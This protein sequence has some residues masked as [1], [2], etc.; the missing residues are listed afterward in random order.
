MARERPT[1]DTV[2]T[3]AGVSRMTVSNAYNRPDQISAATRERVLQVAAGLGYSGPDPT[4]A[5]LRL[6]RTGTVGVVLTERLPY[7]FTDPGMV[8]ILH[9][10]ATELSEAGMALLLVP[11]S[12]SA[13]GSLLRQAMVDA[14]IL[15]S[16]SPDDPA[17]AAAQDRNVPLVT[18]GNPHLPK[19]PTVGVDNR[20]TA[21][22]AAPHLRS[23][24]HRRFAILTAG[25]APGTGLMRPGFRERPEGF[26]AAL[27]GVDPASAVLCPAAENARAAG[28]EAV[29]ALLAMP[30]ATRPTAL[31]AVT[32]ILALG[33]I[34]AAAEL[35][36]DVP[37]QLSVVGYDDIPEAATSHP[38]LTTI[39]QDLFEQGRTAARLAVRQIAGESVR[40]P[41]MRAE[42]V[43]RASTAKAPRA[44][45]S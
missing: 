21:A 37:G 36:I 15:C 26:R 35:G 27:V 28:A 5:S 19:V 33:A 24:G 9:G 34:D 11:E 3:A 31:F 7:A 2:A 29:R 22:L 40:A 25:P 16:L 30:A 44:G 1:L 14:L 13:D 18:V 42:L 32:D 39:R 12:G 6:R 4:A 38:P 23:L 43:V 41:R 10:L 20:R 45:R 8:Q 17:V